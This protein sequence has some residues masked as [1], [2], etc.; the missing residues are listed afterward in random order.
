MMEWTIWARHQDNARTT[1]CLWNISDEVLSYMEIGTK[2]TR[3]KFMTK[4][5]NRD[6]KQYNLLTQVQTQLGGSYTDILLVYS[7]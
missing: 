1:L 2:H 5:S 6:I 4:V 7:R 3:S